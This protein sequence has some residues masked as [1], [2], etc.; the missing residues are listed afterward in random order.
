MKCD[1]LISF[2]SWEERY[3]LGLE[4]NL[5]E[6]NP[7]KL[8]VFRY[9]SYN[10]WKEKNW[11]K[12]QSLVDKNKL[13]EVILDK[14]KPIENWLEIK[15]KIR[16][17][18]KSK[19]VVLDITT[20][21][22]VAIWYILYNCKLNGS[23]LSYIYYKPQQGSYPEWLS[24]DPD[25]PRLLYKMSGIAQLGAPSLLLIT[26]GYDIERL[27]SL[28]Y[29]FEPRQTML[30]FHDSDEPR[31]IENFNNSQHLL[32]TKYNIELIYK[33]DAY[34]VEDSYKLI[35]QKLLQKENETSEETYLSGYNII[36]NS[37]GAKTS[38]I[39][40][41]KIWLKYPQV[42]LSYIPSKE[43]NREYSSG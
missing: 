12:T 43:Y 21:P 7:S 36:L 29:K 5:K 30:F 9:T 13:V 2:L 34:S 10:E 39:T 38:A 27:D 33:Y 8:I 28:I 6:Y 22:R 15:N 37:L 25:K 3:I 35:I 18:C 31:N 11:E 4:K 32:K 26:G 14:S 41:F 42:A 16:E 23:S 24:R 1:V 17:I 19:N 20:M 40:L